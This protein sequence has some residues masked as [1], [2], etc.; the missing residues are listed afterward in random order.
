M[1]NLSMITQQSKYMSQPILKPEQPAFKG[2]VLKTQN[3]Y[4][5]GE[6]SSSALAG[7]FGITGLNKG[8]TAALVQLEKELDT[9]GKKALKRILRDEKNASLGIIMKLIPFYA[10]NPQ[11]EITS[12]MR[13][14]YL[15]RLS[16]FFE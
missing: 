13:S 11:T 1:Y 7:G 2:T 16:K 12:E 8:R 6:I 4:K 14:K 10:K 9:P 15:A 3:V 5:M